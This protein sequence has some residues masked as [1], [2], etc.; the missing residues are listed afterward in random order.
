MF[1]TL[2]QSWPKKCRKRVVRK[3]YATKPY[4]VNRPLIRQRSFP[5][6]LLIFFLCFHPTKSGVI[7]RVK[8]WNN[9]NI[10]LSFFL[11]FANAENRDLYFG[12]RALWLDNPHRGRTIIF[13]ARYWLFFM[14]QISFFLVLMALVKIPGHMNNSG[15]PC[16]GQS[17]L[18]YKRLTATK[19][20]FSYSHNCALSSGAVFHSL[21]Q[22]WLSSGLPEVF[23]FYQLRM[24]VKLLFYLSQKPFDF[25]SVMMYGP[26]LFGINNTQTLRPKLPGM[27]RHMGKSRGLSEQDILQ[28][29]LMYKCPGV[30]NGEKWW[31][32]DDVKHKNLRLL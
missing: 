27:L 5:W 10:S 8:T 7:E 24:I 17:N 2:R 28:T 29:N 30:I 4:C 32:R 1:K 26:R 21:C 15:G 6:H 23:Y 18:A 12:V 13:M 31:R 9:F 20:W 3:L 11:S 25:R 14:H 16:S 19:V 22:V